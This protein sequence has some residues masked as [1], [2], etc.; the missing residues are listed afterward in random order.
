VHSRPRFFHWFAALMIL[1]S[2]TAKAPASMKPIAPRQVLSLDGTWGIAQGGLDTPPRSFPHTVAVPGL[3]DMAQP[4]FA[5]VGTKSPLRQAF[6][7][8]RTFTVPGAV[9]DVAVLK[10]HK[11]RYG[12]KVFLNGHVVGEHLPCFTPALLNVRPFLKSN[13][14]E[15]ELIIRVGADRSCLPPGQPTGWDFEKSRFIPG[16]YDSVELI[17]TGSPAVVNVQAVPDLARRAVRV[18][19]DLDGGKDTDVTV[20]VAE[21]RSGRIVGSCQARVQKALD[22]VV[23]I[24]DCRLWSPEDPF[25]YEVR[26]STGHDAVATR[27][28][29]RSF[30]FDP[31]LRRPVLNGKPY[32]MRGTNVCVYRFFEDAARGDRP[33]R[34]EWVRRLHRQFR[35]MHW[36]SIRYCI[37]FPPDFW[38]DVA[39]EEGFLIQDEFPIWTLSEDP[40]KL[41]A[42]KIIPEYR[43]WLRERWNHPCVVIWDGQ[44]ESHFAASG[45]AI[46]AVRSLD[47][48]HRPWENGWGEPQNST[49]CAESHPY[50][51]SRTAWGQKPFRLSELAHLSGKPGLMPDQRKL[52]VAVIINEYDWLWL[53]RDGNPTSLTAK[54]YEDL[55]GKNSTV[56]QR[57]VLHARCVAALTEFW[58]CHREA[59]GVL[60][61]CGLG[62][63]R[64]GDKPR[65]EGGATSDDFTDIEKLTFEPHFA[66]Y[67]REA[68]NPVGLMLDFWDEEVPAGA[69]RSLKVF[70]INDLDQDW[71]GQVRLYFRRGDTRTSRQALD[72]TVKGLGREVLTF[73]AVMPAEP[74]S[75][76]L[77][78]ELTDPEGR[79]VHSLRDVRV[80]ADATGG[81][82]PR[83]SPADVV[84]FRYA[85]PWWQTALC[86]PDAGIQALVD[87][88]IRNIYQA[89]E[90]KNGLP[91]FH[92]GPTVYRGLWIADG[93]FLLEAAALRGRGAEARAG[94]D[95]LMTFQQPDG[96]FQIIGRYWKESGLVLWAVTRHAFLTGDR[97]WLRRHWPNLR[98]AVAAIQALRSREGAADP[99]APEHRLLPWGFIDGGLNNGGPGGAQGRVQQ[100]Y[101]VPGRHEGGHPCR[102]LAR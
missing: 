21:A 92:V 70:V 59:A 42:E 33:W 58:R 90:I 74:G 34:A 15:N 36:N 101:L 9:P 89:R 96:R 2:V 83:R 48:S 16:I 47:L 75:Y 20:Q 13:G 40:E 56:E 32:L 25:L 30:T 98:R 38:Y 88:S 78:A 84:D 45:E 43:E 31:A 80:K 28:G 62:Y 22:L 37:G 91:A 87:S 4:A 66:E 8:R 52:D 49:D 85:P 102:P 100:C 18:V 11:A 95:Y 3:A 7:Y 19:A 68:F 72:G 60:H 14:R 35:T 71:H 53:T 73:Q 23:P 77:V 69:A 57:R 44:N 65:P 46:R 93:S 1:S 86:L 79:A 24:E 29:M 82:T 55:L 41:R 63:S 26:V 67:V 51:F 6:W 50:L 76:T 17:L 97:D 64:P 94:L 81:L 5:Q 61:F 27:F 10:I 99:K 54:V 12:T 39:D